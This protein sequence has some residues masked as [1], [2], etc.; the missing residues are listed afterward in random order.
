MRIGL[1][2]RRGR[3]QASASS[4]VQMIRCRDLDQRNRYCYTR[5]EWRGLERAGAGIPAVFWRE[6]K[7]DLLATYLK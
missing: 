1:T 7:P 3:S 6:A 2:S 5:V 4:P